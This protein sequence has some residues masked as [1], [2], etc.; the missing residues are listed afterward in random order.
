MSPSISGRHDAI[1]ETSAAGQGRPTPRQ[2]TRKAHWL[3]EPR[4]LSTLEGML[5]VRSE[6]L[7]RRSG[8]GRWHRGNACGANDGGDRVGAAGPG[9]GGAGT[10]AGV[11]M[12]ETADS[13]IAVEPESV[14]GKRGRVARTPGLESHTHTDTE[15]SNTVADSS[16]DT[17]GSSREEDKPGQLQ[18]QCQ[19]EDRCRFGLLLLPGPKTLTMRRWS[20]QHRRSKHFS[21]S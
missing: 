13:S 9:D 17:V 21:P 3:Q 19:W 1:G 20:G 18:C 5:L 8:N 12:L 10:G 6:G 16:T 7:A 4:G 15:H 2:E 14:E 11:E